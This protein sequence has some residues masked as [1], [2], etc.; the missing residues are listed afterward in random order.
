MSRIEYWLGHA[1]DIVMGLFSAI[2]ILIVF[3]QVVT[4]YFIPSMLTDWG[5]EG[6][7]LSDDH[8]GFNR[9]QPSGSRGPP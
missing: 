4:R 7:D 1:E 2:A 5:G 3:Y 9:G 8:S 6:G